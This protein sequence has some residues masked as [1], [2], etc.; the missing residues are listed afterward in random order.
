MTDQ[1][2]VENIKPKLLNLLQFHIQTTKTKL[3]ILELFYSNTEKTTDIYELKKIHDD[4]AL[5][6]GI[7][8]E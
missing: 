3:D 6:L 2:M 8:K 7:P 1:E 5:M 4:L